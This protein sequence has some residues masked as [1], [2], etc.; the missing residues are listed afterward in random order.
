MKDYKSRIQN[1]ARIKYG[2]P[3]IKGT[4]ITVDE[5]LNELASGQTI[6]K[7]AESFHRISTDDV[8]ASIKYS[9]AFLNDSINQLNVR[10][11]EHC[12]PL[13]LDSHY[14]SSASMA[15]KQIE[16]AL[17]EKSFVES[18][19][20]FG[21]K[22]IDSLF[23]I[24]GKHQG[25]KLKLP[26]G[27][28]DDLQKKFKQLFKSVFQVY[29]NYTAHEGIDITKQ[30]AYRIMIIASEL[31]DLIEIT[32]L[33]FTDVGGIQGLI[34]HGDFGT[35]DRLVELLEVLDN[36]YSPDPDT[37]SFLDPLFEQHGFL[38]HHL[39]AVEELGLVQY[40]ESDYIQPLELLGLDSYHPDRIGGYTL[41]PL[42]EKIIKEHKESTK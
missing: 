32:Y 4:S 8:I 30:S 34:E 1:D 26:F 7:I 41:T 35:L 6:E 37:S 31:L 17:K 15:M 18:D 13:Y 36:W 40:E 21:S 33:S 39:W 20:E 9:Q 3:I 27:N 29:R 28:S 11:I 16:L 10:I 12:L 25:I 23:T 38:N 24:G 42:G 22:L 14:G 19:K 2:K 5:I